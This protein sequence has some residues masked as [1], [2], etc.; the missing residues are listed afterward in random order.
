MSKRYERYR[1]EFSSRQL[2]SLYLSHRDSAWFR[3][4]YGA[5]QEE[6][7]ARKRTNRDGRVPAVQQYVEELRA[8]KH[9]AVSY[10]DCE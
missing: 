9:D 5:G 8:K 3:E 2:Y 7:E 10:D 6:A 1:K 4:K